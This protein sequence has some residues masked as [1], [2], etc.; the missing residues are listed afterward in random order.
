VNRPRKRLRLD[1]SRNH[2]LE[3]ESLDLWW[4]V[5]QAEPMLANGLPALTHAFS[6]SRRKVPLM[7]V[8]A[9]LSAPVQRP[10]RP[11]KRPQPSETPQG[12][13]LLTL[14]STN[15]RTMK[16]VRR[17]HRKLELLTATDETVGGAGGLPPEIQAEP[18]AAV[19]GEDEGVD[20]RPWRRKG[21]KSRG[22][23]DAQEAE[24]CLRWMSGKVLEH[25]GFQGKFSVK[26]AFSERY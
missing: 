4:D 8:Q 20:D 12:T 24:G 19:V 15:I 7:N 13:S 9:P 5:V 22:R 3:R 10:K 6:S 18:A 16:R 1:G 21:G 14:M 11:K 2:D 26:A 25:A 17:A 23:A